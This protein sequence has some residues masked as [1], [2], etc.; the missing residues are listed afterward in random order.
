MITFPRDRLTSGKTY[1]ATF[2]FNLIQDGNGK[3]GRASAVSAAAPIA[4][5]VLALMLQMNRY[6]DAPTAR[7][8]LQ[9]S[10][11]SDSFTGT[12]PNPTW[13]YGKLDAYVA[14][15]QLELKIISIQR[16][17]NDI[18]LRFPSIVGATYRVDYCSSLTTANWQ[19]LLNSIPG[20]GNVIV[21]TDAGGVGAG[22]RFYRVVLL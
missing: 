13:G 5:G 15:A 8:I 19:P 9:Q 10:A 7:Q 22:K 3:Y 1:W 2:R 12:L 11:R 4:T 14:L 18:Q 17:G 16:V 6:L 21:T 20:T